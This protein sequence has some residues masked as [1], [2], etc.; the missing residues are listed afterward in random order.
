MSLLYRSL[1]RLPDFPGR[2]TLE[3]HVRDATAT[4]PLTRVDAGFVMALDP[5]EWT[6][7]DLMVDGH[8]EPLTTALFA[9]LLH[10]GDVYV[11]V[12][13]HVGYHT[14]VA[15]Q[16]LGASGRIV[17][18]DPQPYNC[19]HVL[20]NWR[21]NGYTNLSVHVA[22]AGAQDGWFRLEEQPAADK[23]KLSLQDGE[24]IGTGTTFTVPVRR[25][26]GL[27]AAEGINRVALLKI[28][29]EG[30]EPSAVAGLGSAIASVDH[31][32]LELLP[33]VRQQPPSVAPL[34]AMLTEAQFDLRT[35][36]GMAWKNLD[37]PLPENNLWAARQR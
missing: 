17:A 2:T 12:G 22:A 31:I 13:C 11:D 24:A 33:E 27:L 5:I 1:L 25:L 28:D 15:R 29:T 16:K 3:G 8:L 10:E 36:T 37:E 14:L 30:Y 21:V 7:R 35:V 20:E 4:P 18:I 32:V 26:D 23:A 6:Q 34:L 19:Q 9:Q